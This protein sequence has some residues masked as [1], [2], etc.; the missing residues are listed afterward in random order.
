MNFIVR[1]QANISNKYIRFAKWKIRKLSK[2]YGELIYSEIY[3][4]QLSQTSNTYAVTV[5]MGVPGPDIIVSAKSS[6]LKMLWSELS[7]KMK[8]QLRKSSVIRNQYS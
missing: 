3:V 7:Q 4:K 6:N 2:K 5:K 1:N 8:R